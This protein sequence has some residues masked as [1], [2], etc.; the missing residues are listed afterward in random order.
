MTRGLLWIKKEKRVLSSAI[1]H[2][3]ILAFGLSIVA[4][5]LI[6][7]S[8]E[9]KGIIVASA[10]YGYIGA[11]FAGLFFSYG[12]TT[13]IAIAVF[14]LLGATLNPILLGLIGGL[15]AM[16]SDWTMFTLLRKTLVREV[17]GMTNNPRIKA[18][19]KTGL[20]RLLSKG[21]PLAAGIIIASPL[22]DEL[23]VALFGFSK[24]KTKYFLLLSYVC[25]TI[26]LIVIAWLGSL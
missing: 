1:N 25:N 9:I 5:W 8:P 11:L 10:D 17:K 3:R 6:L 4:A 21:T 12:I 24:I 18:F 15:G 22:P 2:H 19:K 7:Q 26:G 14:V 16:F 20:F 13:P 23:A